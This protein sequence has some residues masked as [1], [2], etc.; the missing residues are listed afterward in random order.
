MKITDVTVHALFT[1]GAA[2]AV[3]SVVFDDCFVVHSIWVIETEGKEPYINF[4]ARKLEKQNRHVNTA[5]PITAECRAMV[6]EAVLKAY[7]EKKEEAA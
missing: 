7:E 5:H 3:A 2:K 6:T 4:P 1:E